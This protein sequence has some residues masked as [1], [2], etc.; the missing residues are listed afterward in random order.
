M[1]RGSEDG[2]GHVVAKIQPVHFY[3]KYDFLK[4][5]DGGIYGVGFGHYLGHINISINTSLNMM[6]DAGHLQNTGGGFVGKSLSMHSGQLKF[7]LGEWKVVN[8]LGQ[9]IR[10]AI[11]P[12]QWAGPSQVL[13][14]LL[15]MLIQAGEKM[16]SVNEVL[17][18]EQSNANEPAA[19][20]LA[21]IEQGLKVFTSIYKRVHKSLKNEFDKL[22]RLNR[23]YLDNQTSYKRGEEWRQITRADYR[24][25][26]GVEP[27][28]D[29]AMVSDMQQ[30][31]RAE[32]L[33]EWKDD[34]LCDGIEIRR[35]IFTSAKM[36][37]IDRI[38]KPNPPPNPAALLKAAEIK[39]KEEEARTRRIVGKAQ[40]VAHYAAAIKSLADADATAAGTMMQWVTTQLDILRTQIEALDDDVSLG[41]EAAPAAPG[42]RSIGGPVPGMEAAPGDLGAA[43]VPQA[44]R[45]GAATGAPGPMGI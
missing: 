38:L 35:R 27:I 33:K 25:G 34:P 23:I 14:N 7:K 17:T 31:A 5:P 22:Y 40:S 42:P 21:R 19:T 26:S 18:G 10:D 11:V 44:L 4:N 16:A 41:S 29:P 2:Q 43:P 24:M 13:F 12:L 36:T 3:T 30:L 20:T 45:G 15:G 32:M 6:F 28:S 1:L 9:S 8:A 37:D 39:V